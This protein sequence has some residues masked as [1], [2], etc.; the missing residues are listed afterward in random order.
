MKLLDLIVESI[1]WWQFGYDR[2]FKFDPNSTENEGRFRLY[3]PDLIIKDY[4]YR[5]KKHPWTKNEIEGISY[6]LGKSEE[7]NKLKIQAIRFNKNI[8]TEDQAKEWWKENKK[9][10]RFYQSNF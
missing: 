6:V 7:D 9:N 2:A 1:E 3:P 4:Y 5:S 10:F 8:W